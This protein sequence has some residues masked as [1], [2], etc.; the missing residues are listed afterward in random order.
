VERADVNTPVIGIIV[1]LILRVTTYFSLLLLGAVRGGAE[2]IK[3]SM[4]PAVKQ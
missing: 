2:M 3:K 4:T 1:T